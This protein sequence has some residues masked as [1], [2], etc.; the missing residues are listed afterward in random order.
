MTPNLNRQ[1]R[2]VFD[3]I[4]ANPGKTIREIREAT[5][6]QKADMRISEINFRYKQMTGTKEDLIINVGKNKY[7]EV[8]KAVREGETAFVKTPTLPVRTEGRRDAGGADG[9]Y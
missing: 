3:F 2:L 1:Q 7:G 5:R 6:A 4:K 8:F 9:T